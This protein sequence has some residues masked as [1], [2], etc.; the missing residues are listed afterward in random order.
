[1]LPSFS[2]NPRE[3]PPDGTWTPTPVDVLIQV[4]PTGVIDRRRTL[5]CGGGDYT[6]E[7]SS[8][9]LVTFRDF[10]PATFNL[11]Y[12]KKADRSGDLLYAKSWNNSN[13]E[14]NHLGAETWTETTSL[15]VWHRPQGG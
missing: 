4:T 15:E 6:N 2:P 13:S 11:L 5:D 3:V 8:E 14:P 7:L 10:H 1:M 9:W 12:G